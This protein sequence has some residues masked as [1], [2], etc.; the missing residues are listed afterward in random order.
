MNNI[1]YR[2]SY[3]LLLLVIVSCSKESSPGISTEPGVMKI[4]D[5]GIARTFEIY[6]VSKIGSG[7]TVSYIITGSD[8]LHVLTIVLKDIVGIKAINYPCGPVSDMKGGSVFA[9]YD[10]LYN[11]DGKETAGNVKILSISTTDIKGSFTFLAKNVNDTT[12]TKLLTGEFNG[13]LVPIV[14]TDLPITIGKMMAEVNNELLDFKAAAGLTTLGNKKIFNITGTLSNGRSL[15]YQF[16][17]FQ[18]RANK[19]YFTGPQ[20]KSIDSSHVFLSVTYVKDVNN[21]YV[22]DYAKTG[23]IKIYKY[24]IANNNIQ[25]TFSFRAP[26]TDKTKGDTVYVQQGIFSAKIKQY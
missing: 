23:K 14:G 20:Y 3:I 11:C 12:K 8:S 24:D 9:N 17:N 6:K 4:S 13:P 16:Y 5:D 21:V 18:P 22:E 1:I 2:I 15:M 7:D 19:E 10:T 26:N 25:G